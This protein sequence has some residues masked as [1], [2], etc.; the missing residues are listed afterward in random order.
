MAEIIEDASDRPV[1]DGFARDFLA[2]N[3]HQTEILASHGLYKVGFNLIS[4][5]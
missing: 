1:I 2:G 5:H 4:N 3:N